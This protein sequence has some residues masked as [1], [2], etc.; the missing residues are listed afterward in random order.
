MF[1]RFIT[2]LEENKSANIKT[3]ISQLN[4]QFPVD[5]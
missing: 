4:K 5:Y 3:L 2:I 1:L